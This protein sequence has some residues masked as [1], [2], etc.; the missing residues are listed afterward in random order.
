[1]KKSPLKKLELKIEKINELN[2]RKV[3]G[4]SFNCPFTIPNMEPPLTEEGC[5]TDFCFTVGNCPPIHSDYC[6]TAFCF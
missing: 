3:K 2:A 1:M 5:G 6:P 4:G